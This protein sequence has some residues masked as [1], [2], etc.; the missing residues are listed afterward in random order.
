MVLQYEGETMEMSP[1]LKLNTSDIDVI[2][3]VDESLV[4]Y[5]NDVSL[6]FITG[7]LDTIKL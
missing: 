1:D 3:L 2:A 6:K 4:P 5:V 7:E